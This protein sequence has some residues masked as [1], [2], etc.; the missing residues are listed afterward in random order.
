MVDRGN[1]AQYGAILE[2]RR[3]QAHTACV[4]RLT[5]GPPDI[6]TVK[7]PEK[8]VSN[9]HPL[10][11][12]AVVQGKTNICA[13]SDVVQKTSGIFPVHYDAGTMTLLPT[14]SSCHVESSI[15]TQLV[16]FF[17]L[18]PHISVPKHSLQ[19]SSMLGFLSQRVKNQIVSAEC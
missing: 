3:T 12:S 4:G 16:R 15:F 7:M 9:H 18:N 10:Q 11:G 2:A 14:S 17:E 13:H 19:G 6:G 1:R 8:K 5:V